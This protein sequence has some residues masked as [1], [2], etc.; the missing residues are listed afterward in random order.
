MNNGH[1]DTYNRTQVGGSS[2]GRLP[3]EVEGLLLEEAQE[4]GPVLVEAEALTFTVRI[5]RLLI[6]SGLHKGHTIIIILIIIII[7]IT[8]FM[9][10]LII[11]IIIITITL[12]IIIIITIILI[13]ITIILIII[14]IIILIIT[15]VIFIVNILIII[16]TQHSGH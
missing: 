7:T 14:I 6:V 10:I 4:R 3:D 8:I 13:I 12:I 15:I 11:I 9:L 5:P 1:K 2:V 16:V